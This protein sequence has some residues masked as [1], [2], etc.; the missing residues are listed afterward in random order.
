MNKS[1]FWV[2]RAAETNAVH[3]V[4]ASEIVLDR[5]LLQLNGPTTAYF[6]AVE[7]ML[8]SDGQNAYI[9]FYVEQETLADKTKAEE[10]DK[11]QKAKALIASMTPDEQELLKVL[12]K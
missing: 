8:H 10:A 2:I 3:T 9:P 5:I 12:M 6:Y 4:T 1:M 7:R 11:I